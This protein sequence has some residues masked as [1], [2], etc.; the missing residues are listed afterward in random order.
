MKRSVSFGHLIG[1][2][3]YSVPKPTPDP[4]GVSYPLKPPTLDEADQLL[5]LLEK[6]LNTNNE[7][8]RVLGIDLPP[9]SSQP[10]NPGAMIL[11][12]YRER[13][14]MQREMEHQY[15]ETGYLDEGFAVSNLLEQGAK[16]KS[17]LGRPADVHALSSELAQLNRVRQ[18]LNVG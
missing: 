8:L 13:L 15:G 6:L 17:T 7:V 3:S 10:S 4:H 1:N 14:K 5:N 12:Q 18:R 16:W 9:L 2:Q 11:H